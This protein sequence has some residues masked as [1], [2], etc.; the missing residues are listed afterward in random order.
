M[1]TKPSSWRH[2][3]DSERDIAGNI[4]I[5]PIIIKSICMI[6]H[7]TV[8]YIT[9]LYPP[10]STHPQ[11]TQV[12]WSGIVSQRNPHS[13]SLFC[14]ACSKTGNFVI[15]SYHRMLHLCQQYKHQRH[16]SCKG[17]RIQ[18]L[19]Y[20]QGFQKQPIFNSHRDPLLC[21]LPLVGGASTA[22]TTL[23]ILVLSVTAYGLYA[24]LHISTHY[25]FKILW[26][27]STG[28]PSYNGTHDTP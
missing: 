7:K 4:R 12:M 10:S 18:A 21:P 27:I 28:T 24:D 3:T 11:I 17:L 22:G 6:G 9:N 14:T 23:C 5:L 26:R 20:P 8:A 2:T 15:V 25:L 13:I 19:L 16:T 1:A